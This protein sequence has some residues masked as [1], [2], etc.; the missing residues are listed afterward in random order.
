MRRLAT[1]E[2]Y[3]RGKKR[4][5]QAERAFMKP[6]TMLGWRQDLGVHAVFALQVLGETAEQ[7]LAPRSEDQVAAGSGKLPGEVHSHPARRA[8]HEGSLARELPK[9]HRGSL[10][11]G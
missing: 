5:D 3:W 6:G 8:G 2:D 9:W 11:H 10:P 1:S 4:L 7:I